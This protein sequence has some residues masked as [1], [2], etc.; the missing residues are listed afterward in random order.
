MVQIL[1]AMLVALTEYDDDADNVGQC[2]PIIVIKL[3]QMNKQLKETVPVIYS[4]YST[5]ENISL[6]GKARVRACDRENKTRIRRY[7]CTG[8]EESHYHQQHCRRGERGGRPNPR[9]SP[10]CPACQEKRNVLFDNLKNDYLI[11]VSKMS[12]NGISFFLIN[13]ACE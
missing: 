6:S 3:N 1:M 5:P 13:P 4:V 8:T 11:R 2:W 12:P 10:V 7:I 9:P